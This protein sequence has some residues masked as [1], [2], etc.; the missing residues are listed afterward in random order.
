MY[1]RTETYQSGPVSV[2]VRVSRA[3]RNI[4]VELVRD[5]KRLGSS[6]IAIGSQSRQP[7]GKALDSLRAKQIDPA[8]RRELLCAIPVCVPVGIAEQIDSLS[9]DEARAEA[10]RIAEHNRKLAAIPGLSV[11]Q[12][13]IAEHERYAYQFERMMEDEN[14]DGVNPPRP[15]KSDLAALRAQYPRAAAYLAAESM[16]QAANDRKSGEG[17][18]AMREILDGAGPE[19]LEAADLRWST[20]ASEAVWNS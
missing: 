20:A 6:L 5:G 16:A 11:V 8:T 7:R 14:N 2:N 17:H 4:E 19:A 1:D 10:E 18:K 15:A 3:C 9:A 12:A 13:A